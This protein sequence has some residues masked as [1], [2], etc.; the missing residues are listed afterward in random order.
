MALFLGLALP[1]STG[2]PLLYSVSNSRDDRCETYRRCLKR[3]LALNTIYLERDF[4]KIG[5]PFGSLITSISTHLYSEFPD[6]LN[7]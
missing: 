1:K 7:F 6:F 5:V 2:C 3:R 4:Q